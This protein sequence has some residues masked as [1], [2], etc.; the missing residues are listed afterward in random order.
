[1]VSDFITK[2]LQGKKFIEFRYPIMGMTQKSE[3][4]NNTGGKKMKYAIAQESF[5]S[6]QTGGGFE[7]KKFKPA[8]V[9]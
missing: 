7:S 5:N 3:T 1:M 4:E 2:A 9:C 6:D 8:G